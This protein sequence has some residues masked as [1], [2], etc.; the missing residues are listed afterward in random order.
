M[1]QV[2]Q[3]F[4]GLGLLLFIGFRLC[5]LVLSMLGFVSRLVVCFL[6]SPR[7]TLCFSGLWD[8][9]SGL[10]FRV[11][12]FVGGL[13]RAPLDAGFSVPG[14]Q[15]VISCRA[16]GFR[17]ANLFVA[18][19]CEVRSSPE[20]S[21]RLGLSLLAGVQVYVQ[22]FGCVPVAYLG[23]ATNFLFSLSSCGLRQD[24][25]GCRCSFALLSDARLLEG[26]VFNAALTV[27]SLSVL[28]KLCRF[29]GLSLS[30]QLCV[31]CLCFRF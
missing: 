12:Y 6:C 18:T 13:G 17:F 25:H 2:C 16:V 28:F 15:F 8:F 19:S 23:F 22:G 4:E 26:F 7:L 21:C 3:R 11:C 1:V 27:S 9:F 29:G 5:Y 31:A 20:W 10:G 30:S 14:C 24:L